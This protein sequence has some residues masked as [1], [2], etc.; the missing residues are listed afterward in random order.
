MKGLAWVNM[1]TMTWLTV[2]P[3]ISGPRNN[4]ITTRHIRSMQKA[5]D[6]Y[7][8]N[9]IDSKHMQ[10]KLNMKPL[11]ADTSWQAHKAYI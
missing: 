2:I 5:P 6:D 8:T 3:S 11:I 10:A 1:T 7:T 4:L 9:S